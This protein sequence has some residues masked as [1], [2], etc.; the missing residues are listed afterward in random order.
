MNTTEGC[1]GHEYSLYYGPPGVGLFYI[2]LAHAAEQSGSASDQGKAMAMAFGA[3]QQMLATLP[4]ALAVFGNNTAMYYG[5]SGLAFTLRELSQFATHCGDSVRAA[6]FLKRARRKGNA[7][8]DKGEDVLTR[9]V[10]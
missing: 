2:Q 10:T 7:I 4:Q 3:G 9:D 8:I 6:A 5:S 1:C